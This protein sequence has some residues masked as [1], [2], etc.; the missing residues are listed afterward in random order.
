MTPQERAAAQAASYEAAGM[1]PR[2]GYLNKDG[3]KVFSTQ[4]MQSMGGG[5]PGA[6]QAV[7]GTPAPVTPAEPAFDVNSYREAP[8]SP[9]EEF[10]GGYHPSEFGG[11]SKYQRG[12]F[13][14]RANAISPEAGKWAS[15]R[16]NP[17]PV[18]PAPA[19]APVQLGNEGM[20]TAPAP[21]PTS[22]GFYDRQERSM[23]GGLRNQ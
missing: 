3:P 22:G 4:D 9:F 11:M 18:V 12:Q 10:R 21:R 20:V 14:D 8:G 1:T 2:S 23:S 19:P 15:S 13:Q 17:A 7:L 6:Q 16:F 5:S